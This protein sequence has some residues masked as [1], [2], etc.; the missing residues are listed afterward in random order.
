MYDDFDKEEV[1]MLQVARNAL[2]AML[3]PRS[4]FH[5]DLLN[6]QIQITTKEI[7]ARKLHLSQRLYALNQASINDEN[8]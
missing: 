2:A 5:G 4:D 3:N 8:Q 7:E 1:P 6:P